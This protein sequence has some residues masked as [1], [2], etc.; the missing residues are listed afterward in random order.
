MNNAQEEC[1]EEGKSQDSIA[2]TTQTVKGV[3]ERAPGRP[4]LQTR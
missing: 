4:Q 3:A 1:V 2:I